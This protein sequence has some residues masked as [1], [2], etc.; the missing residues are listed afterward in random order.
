M[1]RRVSPLLSVLFGIAALI[2]T[3]V[4]AVSAYLASPGSVCVQPT[5][6]H[7]WSRDFW[8][9]DTP[10][11]LT[12][13]LVQDTAGIDGQWGLAPRVALDWSVAYSTV[14]Y[15]GGTVSG[16]TLT[17]DGKQHRSGLADSLVG[18]AVNLT[19]EFASVSEATPTISVRLGGIIAGTYDTGF[20]NAPGD[21]A[22]GVEVNLLLGKFFPYLNAG[23]VGDLSYR[24]MGSDTPDAW[25]GSFSAYKIFGDIT[26]SGGVREY[27][28]MDGLDI[29]GPG[30]TLDR[31]SAVQEIN[32]S[33]EFGL[34][35]RQSDRR[36]FSIGYART[37]DGENT[38][39]KNVV[40][41]A[42]SLVF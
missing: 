5:F 37:F 41:V 7:Q 35:W 1:S 38:P 11:A 9:N 10:F 20:L 21:G 32:R 30:F 2:P 29:L 33:F 3:K 14:T 8:F 17:R 12:G 36:S 4:Q 34:T 39:K 22:D 25:L 28:S 6:S 26:F 27:H 40:V 42:G 16:L 31:F 13:D 24:W 18:L 15:E 19:D 23:I